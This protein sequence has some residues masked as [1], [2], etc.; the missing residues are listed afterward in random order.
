MKKLVQLLVMLACASAVRAAE[1]EM[2]YCLR[3]EGNPAEGASINSGT[4]GDTDITGTAV[5]ETTNARFGSQSLKS[6]SS[7]QSGYLIANSNGIVT[8]ENGWTLSFWV[9]PNSV[10]N[11]GDACGFKIGGR[12][13]KIEKNAS[14]QFQ[15]YNDG[16]NT[17]NYPNLRN[18]IPFTAGQWMNIVFVANGS[19]SFDIYADGK[20]IQN[21][22]PNGTN[23]LGGSGEVAITQISIGTKGLH[24]VHTYTPSPLLDDV[25]L[26]NFSATPAEV[27]WLANNQPTDHLCSFVEKTVNVDTSYAA[28]TAN[29]STADVLTL[30]LADG[31]TFNFDEPLTRDVIIVST[32]T[33]TLVADAQPDADQLSHLDCSG[34]QG[35]VLRSWLTPGV[36]GFNFNADAGRSDVGTAD[37]ANDTTLALEIG[38]WCKDG[39]D[40]SGSSTAMFAD[41]FS[42]LSWK[43]ANVYAENATANNTTF[44][45]GYLDDGSGVTIT[46]SNV[47]YES[48]DLIIYCSTDDST[49]SFVAKTVNGTI[50]TWD[51]EL[52]AVVTTEDAGATWGLASAAAGK[53]VI[54]ANTLRINRL[55]G[56]LS[57]AGGTSGN[58]ARGCI[59]AIQ[60]MPAGT[61]TTP[62]LTLTG[63]ADWSDSANWTSQ[64]VNTSGNVN[65]HVTGDVTLTVDQT[66][67]LGIVTVEGEGSLTVR[68]SDG[69]ALTAVALGGTVPVTIGE[70]VDFGTLALSAEVT[71]LTP[72]TSLATSLSGIVYKGGAGSQDQRVNFVLK[73]PNGSMTLADSTFYLGPNTFSETQS[74]VIFTNATVYGSPSGATSEI[75]GVGQA[76]YVFAGTTSLIAQRFWL[77]QGG[78]GR[79][80]VVT[81]KDSATVTVEGSDNFDQNT[82]SIMFGHWDGPSTF[83]IQDNAQF[84]APDAWV[85]V[86]K[87]Y[88]N[89]TININGGTFKTKGILLSSS[90]TGTNRLNLSGGE[91]ILGDTGITSNGSTT[92]GVTVTGT[93][94][95]TLTAD[96]EISQ[97]MS[98]SGAITKG[99]NY[100]LTLGSS[101]RPGIAAIE[102]GAIKV[103]V[104]NDELMS[105]KVRFPGSTITDP[106]AS[107]F[108]AVNASNNESV[109]ILDVAVEDDGT[110]VLT[111]SV[112]PVVTADT[113]IS[114]WETSLTGTVVIDATG[115][116]GG[117]V[118]DFDAGLPS[119]VSEVM[120]IG[121]ITLRGTQIPS[122]VISYDAV[123]TLTYDPGEGNTVTTEAKDLSAFNISVVIAS[124]TVKMGHNKCFGPWGSTARIRVKSGATLD[125]NGKGNGSSSDSSYA[126]I[127]EAGATYTNL[128]YPNSDLKLA[129]PVYKLILEGDATIAATTFNAGVARHWNYHSPI[130]LNGYTL[131]KTGAK[132]FYFSCPICSTEGTLR[133]AEGELRI[134]HQYANSP[135]P[136]M[137]NGKLMIDP[138]ATLTIDHY[139][140][141]GTT[142]TVKTVVLNGTVNF[143]SADKCNLVV[144]GAISGSG[145]TAGLKLGPGAVIKP[146]GQ[147]AFKVSGKIEPSVDGNPITVDTSSLDL[148]ALCKIPLFRVSNAA[149][150][151]TAD[152]VAGVP[153]GWYVATTSDGLG[154]DLRKPSFTISVR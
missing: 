93:S 56:P 117:L 8:M 151:P 149:N 14:N 153:R 73:T 12:S 71:R 126:V 22:T 95:I 57:I 116:E 27:E 113:R 89:H 11:W 51:A 147:N 144:T 137:S 141:D 2:L 18:A 58:N 77:S 145:T 79:T 110:L 123:T 142:F 88:N 24:S 1:R 101:A 115:C 84:I 98:G 129:F 30:N 80:A 69:N 131:T 61:S 42:T 40:A 60:I 138:G 122:G 106:D 68:A 20:F 34:V 143:L 55:N 124:G 32:G 127:L 83:T 120:L 92:M 130:E 132:M 125:T 94:K 119:G 97:A 86:G 135:Q 134:A 53:A 36:I 26:Y 17:A 74:T 50:Y 6:V 107:L 87:T 112:N 28:S 39:H 9:N 62:K 78:S 121:D 154:Y 109:T 65:I 114:E 4:A 96:C 45:Q 35:G 72:V 111:L 38:T 5:W 49:K 133:I 33:I 67:S 46:L 44:I 59:S 99:G 23:L 152:T 70:G 75:F 31:A 82:T 19:N 64:T 85:L 128:A 3:L 25:A 148:A 7:G 81:L 43:A 90:A 47:P 29:A 100:T 136:S 16:G 76:N 52:G 63:D 13:Y 54:G 66:V 21:Y 103:K 10:G 91:L 118:L 102:A 37:Q 15:L 104:S 146:D 150:L 108:S 140:G 41:G 139:Y 105:G 48:Y